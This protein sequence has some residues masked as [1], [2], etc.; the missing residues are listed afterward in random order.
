MKLNGSCSAAILALLLSSPAS[1]KPLQEAET[2]FLRDVIKAQVVA[3]N[4]PGFVQNSTIR[5][6]DRYG[7]DAKTLTE[8]INAANDLLSLREYDR[9]K[10]I[11]EVTQLVDDWGNT[12]ARL[13]ERDPNFCDSASE[14]SLA[15]GLIRRTTSSI[16]SGR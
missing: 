2:K 13:G 15:L 3:A 1:A 6:A 10:L 4:C 5:L 12:V 14:T 9:R 16:P 8:A 7:V 11:P